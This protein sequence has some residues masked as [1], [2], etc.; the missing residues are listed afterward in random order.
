[1]EHYIGFIQQHNVG[2]EGSSCWIWYEKEEGQWESKG[3]AYPTIE[4]SLN[5]LEQFVYEE[6][7][8]GTKRESV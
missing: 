5:M 7:I 4:E 3:Y 2:L 6:G 1:M 8:N